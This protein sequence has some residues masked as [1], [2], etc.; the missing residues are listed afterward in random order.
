M[1]KIC[2]QKGSNIDPFASQLNALPSEPRNQR[3]VICKKWLLSSGITFNT[4]FIIMIIYFAQIT[5]NL[6]VMIELDLF[7]FQH[8]DGLICETTIL[9]KQE[10]HPF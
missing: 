10:M 1:K 5:A 3:N 4:L 2:S 6:Q 8:E 9:Q 7:D